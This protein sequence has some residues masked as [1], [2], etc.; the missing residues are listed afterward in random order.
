MM[1]SA[2][3]AKSTKSF[4][5]ETPCE[6]APEDK[7][8]QGLDGEYGHLLTL[9]VLYTLQGIPM[10]LGACMPLLL[11]QHGASFAD[12]GTFSLGQW[13]FSLKLA[14]A[15]IVDALYVPAFGRRKCW[16]V[17]SQLLIGITMLL[18]SFWLDGWLE[19]GKLN[20][21]A[22][23]CTFFFLHFLCATQDIAVDGWAISMLRAENVGYASTCNATGQTLG[24]FVAFTGFMVL[25]HLE[26]M[27]LSSFVTFWG[28][29]FIVT[30]IAIAI[31]KR[32][33]E[34]R[35]EEQP[36]SVVE[37]YR[38]LFSMLR[39]VPLRRLGMIL[40]IWKVPFAPADAVAGLKLQEYGVPKEHMA[41]FATL[42][43]PLQIFMP[44]AVAK[45][46]AGPLPLNVALQVYRWRTALTLVAAL[47]VSQTPSIL[48]PV[49]WGF[50]CVIMG[51]LVVQ[52]ICSSSMFAAQMAFFARIT[53]T[54]PQIGG[55][56]MTMLNTIANLGGMW[57]TTATYYAIDLLTCHGE[58]CRFDRD[59]YYTVTVVCTVVGFV[60]M[61][62][63][64]PQLDQLQLRHL[65]D[66]KVQ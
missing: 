5:I 52:S 45:R 15:P 36:P 30:T 25:E 40:L 26:L 43:M 39:C 34:C 27:S 11:K 48:S 61:S 4:D 46:T 59:G 18:M 21:G 2:A 62:F 38:Q 41:Y 13:P 32:E 51:L 35:E 57:T 60:W 6:L 64:G 16:M 55:T 19:D 3:K 24:F 58:H 54:M 49:P 8:P 37:A 53:K 17:P 65:D 23:T 28:A 33:T 9:M 31:L 50:Y 56:Y 20:V 14:W 10:G 22:L 42:V 66:W 1:T 7:G 12:M 63:V 44:V 47:V 29:V